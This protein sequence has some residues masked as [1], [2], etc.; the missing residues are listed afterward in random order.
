MRSLIVDGENFGVVHDKKT[1]GGAR[2][3]LTEQAEGAWWVILA[4][5][6]RKTR[7]V[8]FLRPPQEMRAREVYADFDTPA[9]LEAFLEGHDS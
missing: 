8:G 9:V 6:D 2:I 3:Y 4:G 5:P 1:R 7:P